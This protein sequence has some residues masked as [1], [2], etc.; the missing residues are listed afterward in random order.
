MLSTLRGR[1]IILLMAHS[2]T[3]ATFTL[4]YFPIHCHT[5]VKRKYNFAS[6]MLLQEHEENL[7]T[8]IFYFFFITS[9]FNCHGLFSCNVSKLCF[10]FHIY[11]VK[12]QIFGF[13]NILDFKKILNKLCFKFHR[14]FAS[15]FNSIYYVC[16]S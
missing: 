2:M 10:K 11:Y 8:R 12:L 3:Q 9:F 1:N 16:E 14:K 5:I 6:I 4:I 7:T 13:K 15:N